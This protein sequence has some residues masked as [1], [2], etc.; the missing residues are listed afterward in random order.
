MQ[1]V[2]ELLDSSPVKLLKAAVSPFQQG[3]STGQ[4]SPSPLDS[5]DVDDYEEGKFSFHVYSIQAACSP[6]A[7]RRFA[8]KENCSSLGCGMPC[9]EGVTTT[10]TTCQE[11]EQLDSVD[12]S[13][14][15]SGQQK[16]SL[17]ATCPK[18]GMVMIVQTVHPRVMLAGWAPSSTGSIISLSTWAPSRTKSHRSAQ[19]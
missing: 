10:N 3:V 12:D 2:E 7:K 17:W 19:V 14:R 4:D 11:K 9:K 5:P 13:T 1:E 6:P 16:G 15:T 8:C 18:I